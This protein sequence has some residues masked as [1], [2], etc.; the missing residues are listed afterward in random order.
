MSTKEKLN[1]SLV[2][3]EGLANFLW[4]SIEV[5]S[6]V[7]DSLGVKMF[8]FS[9]GVRMKDLKR[10]VLNRAQQWGGGGGFYIKYP[11]FPLN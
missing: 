6:F 7:M 2:I 1:S 4:L 8:K 9:L 10:P 11:N 5:K 3:L